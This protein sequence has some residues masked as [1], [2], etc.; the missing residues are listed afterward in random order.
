MLQALISIVF[1][2]RNARFAYTFLATVLAVFLAFSA[3]LFVLAKKNVLPP[4]PM[5][6]TYC[7]DSKFEWA[8]TNDFHDADLIAVGSSATWRNL[9]TPQFETAGL[10]R[11]ARNMAPC[12]LNMHQ[13]AHYAQFLLPRMPKVDTVLA[14]IS[15]RDFNEC[16][17]HDREF[18]NAANAHLYMF[19]R[20][21]PWWLYVSNFKP[22]VFVDDIGRLHSMRFV[23]ETGDLTI[24][25]AHGDGWLS[26][27]LTWRPH[28]TLAEPCFA[29][30]SELEDIVTGHGARLV[31]V[32]LPVMPEWRD[33][34]YV[35]SAQLDDWQ[36]R[37][38]A[39][40]THDTTVLISQHAG[41]YRDEHFAD[42]VHLLADQIP[43]FTADLAQ[44]MI[45]AGIA[46]TSTP[47]RPSS[48]EGE[49]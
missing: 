44:S 10:A 16:A 17:A 23:E 4:P 42:P 38:A 36:T 43:R 7:I 5:T 30:L 49:R 47:S 15:P 37:V 46:S 6:A 19:A 18:F 12:Y 22:G 20:I 27:R 24:S 21:Y 2:P 28:I 8:L 40:L 39:A 25:S 45:A 32:T 13:T 3:A 35:T 14:V 11:K 26:H 1:A 41:D 48:G 29:A 31:V 9:D 33:S 34:E